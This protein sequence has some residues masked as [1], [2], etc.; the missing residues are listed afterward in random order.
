MQDTVVVFTASGKS[1]EEIESAGEKSNVYYFQGR[2]RPFP[3]F[4]APQKT[5]LKSSH[6]KIL[7]QIGNTTPNK[8]ALTYHS[9]QTYFQIKQ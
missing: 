7:R 8:L 3:Q 5:H 6:I 2:H 9:F 1:H 4:P